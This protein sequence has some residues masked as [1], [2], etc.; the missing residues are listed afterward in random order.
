MHH[1]LV[2]TFLM[3]LI[4]CLLCLAYGVIIRFECF[5]RPAAFVF[6]VLFGSLLLAAYLAWT[7]MY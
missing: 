6:F 5:H 1:F 3:L 2:S 7:L 4:I